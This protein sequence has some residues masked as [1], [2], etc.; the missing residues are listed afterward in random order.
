MAGEVEFGQRPGFGW[1]IGGVLHTVFLTP[2]RNRFFLADGRQ[3]PK[4]VAYH[5]FFFRRLLVSLFCSPSSPGGFTLREQPG[6]GLMTRRR[7]P[8]HPVPYIV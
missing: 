3:T 8:D 1:Q 2:L 6:P 5:R 4:D 7:L